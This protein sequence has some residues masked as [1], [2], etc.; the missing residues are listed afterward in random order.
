M[1]GSI[2]MTYETP[3]S[4]E[5]CTYNGGDVDVSSVLGSEDDLLVWY[6]GQYRST[7]HKCGDGI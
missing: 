7:L 2:V 1:S 3:N 5:Y 4:P 6:C